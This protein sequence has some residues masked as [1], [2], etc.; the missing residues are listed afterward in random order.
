M[1]G[2]SGPRKFSGFGVTDA[3]LLL[4]TSKVAAPEIIQVIERHVRGLFQPRKQVL[5]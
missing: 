3:A 5:I 1:K 4:K 2:S